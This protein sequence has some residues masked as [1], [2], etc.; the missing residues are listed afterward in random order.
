MPRP[1]GS[2]ISIVGALVIGEGAVQAGL[3]SS[4][5]V[6]VIAITGISGF[7]VSAFNDAIILSRI[8]LLLLSA[9]FGLYGILMGFMIILG[10]LCSLRSFGTPYL[11]PQA[12]II[13]S[14]WKD[15]II[16]MPLWL[17]NTRPQSTTWK[18]STREGNGN[19]PTRPQSGGN[20]GQV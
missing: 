8:L 4:P 11:T 1:V 5:M 18:K 20:E 17:F 9:A 3:V 12:P 10:H 19:K 7:V 13:W 2:A 15:S 14:G 16:R 6:I